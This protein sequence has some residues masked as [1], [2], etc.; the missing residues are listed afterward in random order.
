M[1][2]YIVIHPSTKIKI[3]CG[4]QDHSFQRPL[5]QLDVK[6][7]AEYYQVPFELCQKVF[8]SMTDHECPELAAYI[9]IIEAIKRFKDNDYG[10]NQQFGPW[11][12]L[13]AISLDEEF[14]RFRTPAM[15]V[16]HDAIIAFNMS[17]RN[18]ELLN[19]TLATEGMQLVA[20]HSCGIVIVGNDKLSEFMDSQLHKTRNLLRSRANSI[21]TPLVLVESFDDIQRPVDMGNSEFKS[22]KRAWQLLTQMPERTKEE[23]TFTQELEYLKQNCSANTLVQA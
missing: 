17:Q 7:I 5:H 6:T 9:L 12:P 13:S 20:L 19:D 4:I 8:E 23:F 16:F 22:Y 2:L 10:I 1:G 14:I 15:Q 3:M 21:G 18:R 11:I